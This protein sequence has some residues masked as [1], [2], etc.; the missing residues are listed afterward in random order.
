[1]D[2]TSPPPNKDDEG[3]EQEQ[4]DDAS[5]ASSI[6]KHPES[7]KA[8][9]SDDDD[10]DDD[11][12]KKEQE[13]IDR[14]E[15]DIKKVREQNEIE[16]KKQ[17]VLD[18]I[19][20]KSDKYFKR[21]QL[22]Q[23]QQKLA[24]DGRRIAKET[25]EKEWMA[26]QYNADDFYQLLRRPMYVVRDTDKDHTEAAFYI[27]DRPMGAPGEITAYWEQERLKIRPANHAEYVLSMPAMYVVKRELEM[28]LNRRGGVLKPAHE[29]AMGRSKG[30]QQHELG[31]V[32]IKNQGARQVKTAY[33]APKKR[34]NIGRKLPST[35][36]IKLKVSGG[37]PT[38]KIKQKF[39]KRVA[40]G[41][42]M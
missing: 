15:N 22:E 25:E 29:L 18:S 35:E 21:L 5:S 10:E 40:A 1:M 32:I 14:L 9:Y 8:S 4:E 20:N 39:K 38:N 2:K 23:E 42:N 12:D 31:P 6:N 16:T 28:K 41:S 33:S 34:P 19:L 17:E 3:E 24:A 36:P 27:S 7:S 26:F 13:C 37:P 11:N 30:T